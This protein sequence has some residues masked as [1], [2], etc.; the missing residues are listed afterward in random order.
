MR[1]DFIGV[2][3]QLVVGASVIISLLTALVSKNAFVL[4]GLL[5]YPVLSA[6]FLYGYLKPRLNRI[7]KRR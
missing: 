7:K 2:G 5:W 4:A 1:D 6:V 3:L